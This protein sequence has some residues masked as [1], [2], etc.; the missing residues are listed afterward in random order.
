MIATTTIEEAA[1]D[2]IFRAYVQ[3]VLCAA[4]RPGDV[5]VMDSLS[6]HTVSGV[7]E[8]IEKVG[9]EVLYLPPESPDPN[10]RE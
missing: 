5:V 8:I 6:S 10:P 7:R 1:D 3:R 2:N 4:L 9:A